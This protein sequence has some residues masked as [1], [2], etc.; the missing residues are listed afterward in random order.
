MHARTH[1]H[2]R[3][4]KHRH[5]LSC[6]SPTG[7]LALIQPSRLGDIISLVG[8]V[9][10]TAL[11]L[12]F[13]PIIHILVFSCGRVSH[14]HNCGSLQQHERAEGITSEEPLLPRESPLPPKEGC[15]L[16]SIV[17]VTKN[18]AITA[19]G[20]VGAVVGTYAAVSDLVRSI[21]NSAATCH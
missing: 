7:G 8:A 17:T 20:I 19:L 5:P 18:V 2:A 16:R 3:T 14:S 15:G 13:P 21:N 1:T 9:A 11:A 12:T 10:S 6:S 4:H